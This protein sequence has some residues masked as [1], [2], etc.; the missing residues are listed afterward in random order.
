MFTDNELEY[1]DFLLIYGDEDNGLTDEEDDALN[2][3]MEAV[4]YRMSGE[5]T[6]RLGGVAHDLN[7]LERFESVT[8]WT[9][10]TPSTLK[11]AVQSFQKEDYLEALSFARNIRGSDD[12]ILRQGLI[13]VCYDRLFERP[14]RY[15]RF[16]AKAGSMKYQTR[17]RHSF[18]TYAGNSC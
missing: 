6:D 2:D 11:K 9:S 10:P 18:L 12:K 15:A 8:K 14:E 13:L 16:T 5:E 7:L 17:A 3:K 1:L 4:Y